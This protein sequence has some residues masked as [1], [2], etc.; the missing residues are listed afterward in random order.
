M[1]KKFDDEQESLDWLVS[2]A[3][4]MTLIACFFI[5]MMAFANYDDPGFNTKAEELSKHFKKDKYKSSSL[6]LKYLEEEITRHQALKDA[7]KISVKDGELIVS[8]SGSLLFENGSTLLD[9]NFLTSLD[10]MIELIKLQMPEGRILVEGH[11]DDKGDVDQWGLSFKRAVEVTKRFEYFGF[12]PERIS[13]LAR[14][15]GVKYVESIDE[16]G[17][18][19]DE[20]ARFNRRVVI[21][22]LTTL[23]KKNVKFGFGVYFKDSTEKEKTELQEKDLKGFEINK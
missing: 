9:K 10:A 22:V 3:D 13:A 1:A 14:S 12:L 20:K 6:K 15:N 18:W 7:T 4:M 17:N 19:S 11:A 8:F 16:K 5:L 21:R 2:Y 23:E